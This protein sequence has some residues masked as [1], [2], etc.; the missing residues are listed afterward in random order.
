MERYRV[1]AIRAFDLLTQLSQHTNVKLTDIAQGVIDAE[2]P[3][4]DEDDAPR[5]A[6]VTR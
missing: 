3:P 4:P 2:I 1:D 6:S 5:K